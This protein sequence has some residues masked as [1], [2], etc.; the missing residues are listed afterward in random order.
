MTFFSDIRVRGPR[1]GYA[2]F[3]SSLEYQCRSAGIEFEVA[4]VTGLVPST[5]GWS[6]FI[7]SSSPYCQ[8]KKIHLTSSTNLRLADSG[9][10][11]AK[12]QRF[13]KK[14]SWIVEIEGCYIK[15]LQSYVAYWKDPYIV[16]IARI[17]SSPKINLN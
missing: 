7:G 11:I 13:S 15:S 3:I 8:A 14:K 12:Q 4:E 1:Y 5:C 2:D 6:V 9:S 16:R 17:I 10:F